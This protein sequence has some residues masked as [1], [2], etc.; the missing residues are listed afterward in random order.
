LNALERRYYHVTG[1]DTLNK[2]F[3]T[4]GAGRRQPHLLRNA[5]AIP[6]GTRLVISQLDL[7]SYT[8]DGA[9]DFSDYLQNEPFRILLSTAA[10]LS[11]RFPIIT[12]HGEL[13]SQNPKRSSPITSYVADGGFVDNYGAATALALVKAL[14]ELRYNPIVVLITNDPHAPETM[15]RAHTGCVEGPPQTTPA[16]LSLARVG[17]LTVALLGITSVWNSQGLSP[18]AELCG[19]LHNL[20]QRTLDRLKDRKHLIHIGI[21]DNDINKRI[22]LEYPMSWW[23]SKKVQVNIVSAL[24]TD[25]NKKSIAEFVETFKRAH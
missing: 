5:A 9:S 8:N 23:L 10:G 11:A 25:E 16:P 21:D 20:D 6:S 12:P 13:R 14:T 18:L 2:D 15:R 24:D 7:K 1:F 4:F 22:Q 19:F 17:N 3:L